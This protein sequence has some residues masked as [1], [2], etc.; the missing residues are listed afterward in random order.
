MPMV[1][2]KFTEALDE[3]MKR[4]HL[5]EAGV[6]RIFGV[7][8]STYNG[9]VKRLAELADKGSERAKKLA[10]RKAEDRENMAM[11]RDIIKRRNGFVPGSRTLQI[12]LVIMYKKYLSVKKIRMYKRRMRLVT[13]M[14]KNPYKNQDTYLHPMMSPGNLVSRCFYMGYRRVVLVDITYVRY[15]LGRN[16]CYHIEFYDPFMD[17]VLGM[18][19]SDSM[20]VEFVKEAYEKM[21]TDHKD[22]FRNPG[23]YIHSDNGSQLIETTFAKLVSDCGFLRSVSRPGTPGDN[24]AMEAQFS[25]LK[26]RLEQKLLLCKTMGQVNAMIKG[27]IKDHEE[28]DHCLSLGGL[29]PKQFEE[30]I[31]TGV[32]PLENYYGVEADKLHP[33]NALIKKLK[34]AAHQRTERAKKERTEHTERLRLIMEL[35]QVDPAAVMEKDRATVLSE[36]ILCLKGKQAYDTDLK[37]LEVM[38]E[39][40]ARAIGFIRQAG[41]DVLE[42]LKDRSNW[43]DY[44]DLQYIQDF[45]QHKDGRLI[46]DRKKLGK[47]LAGLASLWLAVEEFLTELIG[48]FETTSPEV[49]K[50]LEDPQN[51]DS[52]PVLSFLR[53]QESMA[54]GEGA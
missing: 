32:Y 14:E 34:D 18:A 50:E 1:V 33:I 44:P 49:R 23:V 17:Q 53:G 21:L 30:Y 22:E 10:A 15:D 48:F 39:K 13:T 11:I 12:E 9:L 43:K 35:Q 24:R 20:S 26:G 7:K 16:V 40:I 41:P 4:Y 19:T 54:T 6:L 25:R 3:P 38:D 42:R 46:F 8:P 45:P 5:N 29:T 2:N 37:L 31:L 47:D 27:F 36:K 52:Y 51:W 28:N